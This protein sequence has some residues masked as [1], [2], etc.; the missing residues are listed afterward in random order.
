[1]APTIHAE[2]LTFVELLAKDLE[3][4]R[5]ELPAFPDAVMRI[6]FALQSD[7]NRV[8]DIV[9]LLSSEPALA[10]RLLQLANA[11]EIRRGGSKI[12]NLHQAVSRMGYDMVRSIAISFGM[13]QLQVNANYS[14]TAQ[15]ELR[16]AWIEAVHVAAISY[17]IA[18]RYTRLNP[19]EA[20]LAGLLHAM[21]R[22]Y[23]VKRFEETGSEYDKEL[24]SILKAW[25]PVLGRAIAESWGLPEALAVAI[26]QQNDY[27]VQF[28]GPVSLTE[29]LI[30][31]R[32]VNRGSADHEA[33]A[34]PGTEKSNRTSLVFSRLGIPSDRQAG[35]INSS[36]CIEEIEKIR[37]TLMG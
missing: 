2:A 24:E 17:V 14:S 18:D 25:H 29:V 1:M 37:T 34:D 28:S 27:D 4:K 35:A 32:L 6:Q 12:G 21:G 5:F 13:R 11:W 33:P 16:A 23:I 9:R 7:D 26:E 8:D 31:A 10:A 20:L 19:S 15:E 36:T 22:L 30:A 3:D